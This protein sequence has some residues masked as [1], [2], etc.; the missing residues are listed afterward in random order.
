MKR[1][2][3]V[4]MLSLVYTSRHDDVF[5][6]QLEYKLEQERWQRSELERGRRK[7]E[8]ESRSSQQSLGEMEKSR[9]GLEELI[10][11]S[12]ANWCHQGVKVKHN[13]PLEKRHHLALC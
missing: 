5:F 10:K 3:T 13:T 9:S 1:F 8:G 2:V 4:G 12:E 11:R 6:A 7:V